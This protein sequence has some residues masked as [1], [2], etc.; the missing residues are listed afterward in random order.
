MM[1][2]DLI[3]NARLDA[4]IDAKKVQ[5]VHVHTDMYIMIIHDCTC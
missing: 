5:F 2:S 3:R 4:K 1:L